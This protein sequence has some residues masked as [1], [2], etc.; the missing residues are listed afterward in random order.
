M[1]LT[2]YSSI[3]I[4]TPFSGIHCFP[5]GWGFKQ[6]TSD[7]LKA[8]MKVYLPSIEGHVPPEMIHAVCDLIKFSYLVHQ[9]IHDTDLIQ[10]L[11]DVLKSFY[12]NCEIFKSLGIIQH[13]N[14]P[15]QHALK[16]YVHVIHEYG[17]PNGLC[18]SM[19]DNKH[20]KAVKKPWRCSN[21][22]NMIK[23][24]LLTNQWLDKLSASCAHFTMNGMLQGNCLSE[25][26]AMLGKLYCWI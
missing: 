9:D 22:Y 15:C 2:F 18:S 24:M 6:W 12:N 8:L 1:L 4:I 26:L 21:R 3:T 16:H 7:D 19:T 25:T 17:S 13:F 23:Q 5:Q 10:A 11:C 14:Y 20:I